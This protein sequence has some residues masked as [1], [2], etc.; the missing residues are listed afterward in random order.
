MTPTRPGSNRWS[1]ERIGECATAIAVGM[2]VWGGATVTACR[3]MID[4]GVLH[5]GSALHAAWAMEYL[6]THAAGSEKSE[7]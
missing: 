4:E 5:K 6:A 2:T 1:V 3:F 7:L